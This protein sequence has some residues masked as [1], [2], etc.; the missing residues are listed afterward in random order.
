MSGP[1]SQTP[2]VVVIVGPTAAG[3]S[4]VAVEVATRIDGE[5]ISLDSRQIYRDMP[6][7][8]AQPTEAILK[9]IAHHLYGIRDPGQP[10]SAGEYARLVEKTAGE[11]VKRGRWPVVCGGSGLY[12]RALTRGLFEGSRTDPEIRRNLQRQLAEKGAGVL[13]SR[14]QEIDREY[15]RIV[16][17]NNHKRLLRALEIYEITGRPPTEHFRRQE[18]KSPPF[19]YF[20]VYLRAGRQ[21]LTERIARRTHAMLESGWIDEVKQLLARGYDPH[22]APMDSLGYREIVHYLQGRYRYDEMVENIIIATRQ[23]ARKQVK[24]FDREP[25]DFRFDLSRD[26]PVES[27]AVRIVDRVKKNLKA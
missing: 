27:L 1:D 5:I 3:K 10:V 9:G 12:Y 11:I 2:L 23:Y 17:P 14:L 25:V 20:T 6:I 26:I 15:A 24:W 22:R 13:L 8:T 18:K 16:H 21:Y 4:A 19:L 7:G